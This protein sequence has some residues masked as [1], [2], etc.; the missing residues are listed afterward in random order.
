VIEYEPEEMVLVAQAGVTLHAAGALA[1]P[2]SQRLPS[3]VWPGSAATLGGALAANRDGLD[4]L[5]RGTLRD[6]MLGARVLHAD[7]TR[8]KTGGKVV[9]NVTGF[10]L[11]KLYVGSRGSLVWIAEVNLRLIPR[12][13]ASGVVVAI[14]ERERAP[15]VLLDVHRSP[16]MPTA[17]L[18]VA[19]A[20]SAALGVPPRHVALVARFEGNEP[21]VQ[22]QTEETLR[23]SGGDVWEGER[24]NTLYAALGAAADAAPAAVSLRVAS[25]GV[26]VLG[27]LDCF[28]ALPAWE[29]GGGLVAQFG[30]GVTRAHLP[31]EVSPSELCALQD[32]LVARGAR[33]TVEFAPPGLARA[34]ATDAGE[35]DSA[36]LAIRTRTKQVY[37]PTGIFPAA[38]SSGGWT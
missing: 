25:L 11:A 1:A 17:W 12:P 16:L 36:A 32:C 22:W 9:K 19:G 5:R 31:A 2:H 34:A 18:V 37:D 20:A 6:A 33:L 10:D 14:V 26:E 8:S 28:T 35:L 13:A 23:R 38:G 27:V 15:E 4:R 24:G 7:G 3:D 29:R 30:V 21:S